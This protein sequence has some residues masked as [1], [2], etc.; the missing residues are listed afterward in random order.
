MATSVTFLTQTCQLRT[1]MRILC[2][3]LHLSEEKVDKR[4]IDLNAALHVFTEN[5]HRLGLCV[6]SDIWRKS[7]P[8]GFKK[9]YVRLSPKPPHLVIAQSLWSNHRQRKPDLLQQLP[10]NGT[11]VSH[12]PWVWVNYAYLLFN[13]TLNPLVGKKYYVRPCPKTPK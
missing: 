4:I 5:V 6:L 12:L 7:Y 3:M 11:T 9:C 2:L 10:W 8:Y 1:Q 13:I